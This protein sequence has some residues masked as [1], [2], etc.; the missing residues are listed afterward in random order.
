MPGAMLFTRSLELPRS[1][2]PLLE[3][4]FRSPVLQSPR[5]VIEASLQPK[6]CP[7]D[8]ISMYVGAERRA[9]PR[10]GTAT[11]GVIWRDGYSVVLCIVRDMSPAGA[12]LVLP[13]RV[14]PLPAD[15]ALTFDRVTRRC[16]A[17]WQH[18]GR[19]GVKFEPT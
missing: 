17:V 8:L 4:R 15:F 2:H 12:G 10:Y 1:K 16:L 19:M 9:N 5:R 3:Q 7:A 14:S 6:G 11:E 18:S 13:D